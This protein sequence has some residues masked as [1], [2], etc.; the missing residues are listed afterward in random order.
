MTTYDIT[1]AKS[2]LKGAALR[3]TAA[4]IAVL[5]QLAHANHPLS[6]GD[7]VDKLREFGFDQSTIFRVLHELA[8]AGIISKLDLG[9]QVRR[10]ELR[11]A[12]QSDEM[13]HPHFMCVDCG[14][15]QCL[16]DYSVRL[17]PTQANRK[18]PLGQITEVLL[19]GH[20]GTC[21]AS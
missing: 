10:F 6:H 21:Q 11:T 16:N 9:D 20:C 14:Q 12:S 19:K 2:L 3:S 7:V 13:E 17:T 1:W 15:V 4:R 5:Q 18:T 8:D